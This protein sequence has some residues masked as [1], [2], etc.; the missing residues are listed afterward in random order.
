MKLRSSSKCW[1]RLIQNC[2]E[3]YTYLA[4]LPIIPLTW[5]QASGPCRQNS[6]FYL[7]REATLSEIPFFIISAPMKYKAFNF[8]CETR[9]LSSFNMWRW[10][11]IFKCDDIFF[12]RESTQPFPVINWVL[13]RLAP[14]RLKLFER[15]SR[16]NERRSREETTCLACMN[17]NLICILLAGNYCDDV[18]DAL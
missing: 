13:C 16:R 14:S 10:Y 2:N 15:R 17:S 3:Q 11:V 7:F 5:T 8:R 1:P 12:S 18:M 6:Y 4:K 9:D